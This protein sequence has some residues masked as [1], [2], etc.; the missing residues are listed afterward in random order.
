M[1][2]VKLWRGEFSS[3]NDALA[4]TAIGCVGGDDTSVAPPKD[5]GLTAD[6]SI[7]PVFDASGAVDGQGNPP[8]PDAGV[9]SS[10]PDAGEDAAP[11]AGIDAAVDAEAGTPSVVGVVA[12]ATTSTSAHYGLTGNLGPASAVSQSQNYK[13][14]GGLSVSTQ[15]VK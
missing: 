11:D 10:V 1:R 6:G 2:V 8:P 9:D 3:S 15:T 4:G 7:L 14:V 13:L 12:G 5:A